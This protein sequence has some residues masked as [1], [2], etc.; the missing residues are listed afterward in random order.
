[1]SPYLLISGDFVQTGGMDVA[2]YSLAQY[3]SDR[4]HEVH[5]VA[6]RVAA[7]LRHRPNVHVHRAPKPLQSYLLGEPFLDLVGRY[8]ASRLQRHGVR[9]V[10]NGGNC[11]C[12]AG[13][14]VHYVH[15]AYKPTVR[16]SLARRWRGALAHR[17]F[18]RK[19][20]RALR[21]ATLI[22]T[23]SVRT[24]ADVAKHLAVAPG[25]IHTVYYGVDPDS[26]RPRSF[27]EKVKMRTLL[28]WPPDRPVVLFVGAVADERKGFGRLFEAWTRLCSDPVWDGL[29]AVAGSDSAVPEW[30]TRAAKAGIQSRIRFLGFRRD[31]TNVLAACDAM[32]SPARYEAYGLAVHEALCSG[33]AAFVTVSAGVAERY[34]TV[35]N[36]LLIRDPDDVAELC[37][38]LRDWR[39][40]MDE[41]RAGVLE[42]SRALR[43]R[44]WEQACAQMVE[45]IESA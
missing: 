14:W 31:M 2:N 30:K 8:W 13:N 37:S 28:G 17:V 10:A 4:G 23:N 39:A 24:G 19:E 22:I 44:T 35:L 36:H 21:N 40:R 3:L 42:F 11:L 25:C 12:K 5:L 9:V 43:S 7:E 16:G 33:V 26:F 32:V 6:H 15:A 1:M 18:L 41:Y 45:V 38:R 20:R 34:P 29:L 27:E